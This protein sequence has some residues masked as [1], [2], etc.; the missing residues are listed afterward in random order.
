M[1]RFLALAAACLSAPGCFFPTPLLTP[2]PLPPG[3]VRADAGV[4]PLALFG[5]GGADVAVRF[6]IADGTDASVRGRYYSFFGE[7]GVALGGGVTTRVWRGAEPDQAVSLHLGGSVTAEDG[8]TL[9]VLAYPTLVA[10]DDRHQYG[11]RAV[12]GSWGDGEA[13]AMAGPFAGVRLG[14]ARYVGLETAVYLSAEG[15]L[16]APALTLG[17]QPTRAP[18]P[19]PPPSGAPR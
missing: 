18:S 5:G 6:G 3:Q 2:A 10:G 1:L 11:V 7:P 4:E 16:V 15:V 19:V 14:T 12:V 9:S 8:R 17:L 13:V